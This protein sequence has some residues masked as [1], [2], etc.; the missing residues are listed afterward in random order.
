M[1]SHSQHRPRPQWVEG[2]LAICLLAATAGLVRSL[3]GRALPV[4]IGGF[5]APY[6]A[7]P[8]GKG[9]RVDLD[10]PASRDD[11]LVFYFR[12]LRDGAVLRLPVRSDGPLTLSFRAR[13]PVRSSLGAFVHGVPVREVLVDTG[14][15]DRYA[16]LVPEPA[17]GREGLEIALFLR[18]RPVVTGAHVGRPE[19]FVDEV[20]VSGARGLALAWPAVLCLSVCPVAVALFARLLGARAAVAWGAGAAAAALLAIAVR[21]APFPTL[22]AVPR[23]TPLALAAGAAVW[24]ALR[25]FSTADART[26]ARWGVVTASFLAAHASLPFF[27]DHNPPD[28]QTHIDR[29]L[30]FA[31]VPLEYHALRRY[32]S[33]LPTASQTAAPATDLFGSQVLVPYPPLPYLAYYA[34]A[35][36]G[37]DPLWSMTALDALLAVLVA[38]LLFLSARRIWDERAAWLA[39]C[40]YLL[41]LAVWHHV[42]RAHAP[43]AFGAALGTAALVHLASRA[44]GL[45][46]AR[47]VLV[48]GAALGLA[49]LGYASLVVQFGL[50]GAVLCLLLVVDARGLPRRARVGVFAALAFGGAL[51]IVLYYGH[52]AS[53]ML[54]GA[55]G[56]EAEPSIFSGKTVLGIFRNEGRQSFR[57]WAMGFAWPLFAGLACLPVALLRARP[58]ARP[59]LAAWLAAWVLIV[60]LKDPLFFPKMLRWAKEDQFV[61]PLLALAIGAAVSAVPRLV[62]RRALAAAAIAGYALLAARDFYYQSNTLLL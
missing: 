55:P 28:L 44:D 42:G 24:A 26:A 43:A 46:H 53:G 50:L 6:R 48:A 29:T 62:P 4:A 13:A 8:W 18:G 41:D 59:V 33:H 27:P 35:R 5:D 40:L 56:V 30:D 1:D 47:P 60:V 19:V 31:D 14:P 21:A 51:A 25:R 52:Y 34:L 20:T 2:L 61:S 16:L 32:G 10:P 23:L 15:W 39:S 22:S 45:T 7:G 11:R 37:A 49:V 57:V 9:T 54:S 58:S 12:P 38:P 3:P 36:L 17:A